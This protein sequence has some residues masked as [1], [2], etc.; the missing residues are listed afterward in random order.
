MYFECKKIGN[1][2]IYRYQIKMSEN[3]DISMYIFALQKRYVAKYR[4]SV[5]NG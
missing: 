3:E 4:E 1:S 5:R 2:Q